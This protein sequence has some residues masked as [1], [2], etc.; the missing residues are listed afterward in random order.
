MN[1][2]KNRRVIQIS[3]IIFLA[4]YYLITFFNMY[5]QTSI[6]NKDAEEVA[7]ILQIQVILNNLWMIIAPVL[8]TVIIWRIVVILC[9]ILEDKTK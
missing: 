3:V 2:T 6:V 7:I 1:V 9:R 5:V 8:V 4:L